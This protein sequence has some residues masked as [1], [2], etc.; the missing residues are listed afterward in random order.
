[1]KTYLNVTFSSEGA[2][3]SEVINRLRSLGF[4]PVMGDH[5][6]VY[7]WANSANEEDSL[8]FA[9]K[10]QATLEGFKVLFHVETLTD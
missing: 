4:K 3:P 10:I 7:E 9:D 8:W 6:M 5:D 2:K 1:M